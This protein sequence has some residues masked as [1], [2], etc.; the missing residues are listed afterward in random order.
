MP[1]MCNA[2]ELTADT[3]MSAPNAVGGVPP[4]PAS[5]SGTFDSPG[6]LEQPHAASPSGHKQGHNSGTHGK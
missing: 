4:S 3:Y 2:E 6:R 5:L 1:Y